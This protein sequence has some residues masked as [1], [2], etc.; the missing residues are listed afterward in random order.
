MIYRENIRYTKIVRNY[1]S[2]FLKEI[3]AQILNNEMQYIF[4]SIQANTVR[5]KG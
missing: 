2:Q 4:Y 1:A 5:K 3:R